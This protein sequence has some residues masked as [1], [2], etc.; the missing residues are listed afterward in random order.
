MKIFIY[1]SNNFRG[2]T[3]IGGAG[4]PGKPGLDGKGSKYIAWHPYSFLR[5]F[6]M[7]APKTKHI[8]YERGFQWGHDT[9]LSDD[10]N[11]NCNDPY[12]KGPNMWPWGMK[13]F[14]NILSTYYWELRAFCRL[15]AGSVA[16]SFGSPEDY[17]DPALTHAGC[18]VLLAHYPP[19]DRGSTMRDLDAH[20]DFECEATSPFVGSFVLTRYGW[21][22][23]TIFASGPDRA[24]EVLNKTGKWISAPEKSG[25]HT[26]G[27]DS[28]QP[29]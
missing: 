11:D 7:F 13:G 29:F 9:K 1:S 27:D 18:T 10:T 21:T 2:Y 20:T 4:K 22:V 15:L 25:R 17:F 12:M 23:F 5:T 26:T 24:L 14:E 6:K 16:L 28:S 19:Q 8:K 3:P